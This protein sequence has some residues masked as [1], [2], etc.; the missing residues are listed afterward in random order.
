MPGASIDHKY[1]FRPQTG[2]IAAGTDLFAFPPRPV[3]T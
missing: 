3:N 2:V 1:G